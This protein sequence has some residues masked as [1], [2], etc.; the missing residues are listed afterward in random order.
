MYER[1]TNT[2]QGLPEKQKKKNKKHSKLPGRMNGGGGAGGLRELSSHGI[3]LSK[4]VDCVI[5][6]KNVDSIWAI[7]HLW[8]FIDDLT[9]V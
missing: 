4:Q 1:P 2:I 3:N 7:F 6:V 8:L 5:I 9:E